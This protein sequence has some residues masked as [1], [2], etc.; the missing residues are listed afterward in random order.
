MKKIFTEN[1]PAPVGPYSQAVKANGFLFISGQLGIDK[2]G[3]A[4]K[5]VEEQTA[6]ALEN[7]KAIL[8]EE[9]LGLENIVKMTVFLT[10]MGNFSKMNGV[11]KKYLST[12]ARACVGVSLIKDF[13]VEIEAVAAYE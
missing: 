8:A 11:Y 13:H 7:I 3:N 6:Q 2:E 9:N 1:A 5:T 4:K 10:D 12:P